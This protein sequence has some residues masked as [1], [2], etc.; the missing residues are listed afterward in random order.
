MTMKCWR[1]DCEMTSGGVCHRTDCLNN[2][3][4]VTPLYTPVVVPAT[5]FVQV[6]M[7]RP[8]PE[9]ITVAILDD[10][11]NIWIMVDQEKETYFG[12]Q[13]QQEH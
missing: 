9:K 11:G 5:E 6:N 4:P 12:S 2:N 10:N 3:V 1:G 13:G 7:Q 8:K